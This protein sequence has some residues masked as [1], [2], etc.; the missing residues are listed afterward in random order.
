MSAK[1]VLRTVKNYTK[2]YSSMQ[3]KVREATSNQAGSPPATLMSEI[4]QATY[5]QTDFLG[6][7]EIIDKRMNDKGRLWRHVFKALVLLEYLLYSGSP[8]VVEYAIDNLFVVKTLRE[9]QH[10]DES[11]LDQ[12][13]N[14]RTKAKELTAVLS[15]RS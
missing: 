7:M 4:A 1:G 14:V 3:M 2:G 8:Y 12:G 13:A 5:N 9:F 6:V 10:I 15:D 11:G